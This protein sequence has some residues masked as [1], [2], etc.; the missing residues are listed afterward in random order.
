MQQFSRPLSSA[1]AV[2]CFPSKPNIPKNANIL[3]NREEPDEMQHNAAFHQGLHCLRI[4][5]RYSETPRGIQYI[6]EI[7]TCDPS[8]YTMD[9]PDLT[10][11]NFM[12]NSIG[13]KRVKCEHMKFE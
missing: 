9:H 10:V 1:K 13:L 7:I 12:G 11:S 3:A 4:Q 5:N 6:L 2:F 8:I